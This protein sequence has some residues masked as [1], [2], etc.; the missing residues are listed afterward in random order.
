LPE[1]T[2]FHH[3][4]EDIDFAQ[5]VVNARLATETELRRRL[6]DRELV[7]MSMREYGI[8]KATVYRYLNDD[9]A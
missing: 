9:S 5:R 2:L 8:S 6:A 4:E 1:A 7:T 3:T